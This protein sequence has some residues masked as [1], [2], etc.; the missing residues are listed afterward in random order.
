MQNTL[1]VNNKYFKLKKSAHT[2]AMFA[3]LVCASVACALPELDKIASGDVKINQTE[4]NTLQVN[5]TSDKAIVDWHR[6]NVDAHEKVQFNQPVDGAI[7]NRIDSANGMSKIAGQLSGNGA[8]LLVNGAGILFTETS[9]VNLGSL[10]AS[11]ADISD[12]NFNSESFIFDHSAANGAIINRGKISVEDLALLFGTN[13]LNEGEINVDSGVFVAA[14]GK[15]L[16]L[17][18]GGDGML[19]FVIDPTDVTATI[20]G[21]ALK[22]GVANT[23]KIQNDGGM[24]LAMANGAEGV[25]D[26]LINISG[27]VR[28]ASV[29]SAPGVILLLGGDAARD[30]AIRVGGKIDASSTDPELSGGM[31]QILGGKIELTQKAVLD[32][33]GQHGGAV[34]VGLPERVVFKDV[35]IPATESLIIDPGVKILANA[36]DD[37]NGGMVMLSSAGQSSCFAKVSAVGGKQSGDGGNVLYNFPGDSVLNKGNIDVSA[38]HGAEGKIINMQDLPKDSKADDLISVIKDVV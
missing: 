2:L 14:A 29:E 22:N 33:S 21:K 18:L 31:V 10:I 20:D 5:Q 35:V 15:K 32:A 38:A 11:A 16:N 3:G 24:V 17:D 6:F 1:L 9:S 30:S 23:G 19:N 13:V 4:I 27:E 26:N 28:A 7:L 37:G 25:F 12:S 34:I 36:N 8:V